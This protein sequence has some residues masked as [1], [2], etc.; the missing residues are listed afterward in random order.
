MSLDSYNK[1]T[2]CVNTDSCL[3]S[4][5]TEKN[6]HIE[7]NKMLSNKK[8]LKTAKVA[9]TTDDSTD[10]DDSDCF[11]TMTDT[12][13]TTSD[14]TEE[15]VD[16]ESS[17]VIEATSELRVDVLKILTM[18]QRLT[19]DLKIQKQR[20]TALEAG[21]GGGSTTSINDL[22]EYE[23][24]LDQFKSDVNTEF[25]NFRNQMLLDYDLFK[26]NIIEASRIRSQQI[27]QKPPAP[28]KRR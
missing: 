17:D 16:N 25:S 10:S 4:G 28:G 2:T 7:L 14:T 1:T 27:T 22:N 26:R 8:K 18:L 15:I 11:D 5:L 20:I 13:C 12:D 23:L 24:K 21:G 9:S 19:A 3:D 6:I